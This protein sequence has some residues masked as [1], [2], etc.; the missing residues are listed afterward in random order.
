MPRF[1][2]QFLIAIAACA[3]TSIPAFAAANLTQY[4]LRVHIFQ[5]TEHNHYAYGN[6]QWVEGEGRANL[7]ENSAPHAF[8]FAF[9]CGDRIMT[10]S[11]YE[12]YPAKWKKQGQSLEVL[13]PVL[14]KPGAMHSCELKVDLKD[15][16]YFRRNGNTYTEPIAAYKQW[17]DKHQYDPEHGQNEP[18]NTAPEPLPAAATPVPPPAAGDNPNP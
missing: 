6:L 9:R 5:R 13:Y 4:P 14:G 3:L 10:S 16:A 8:D 1:P 7:F 2:K 11:G 12:T 18:V 15:F 17:M